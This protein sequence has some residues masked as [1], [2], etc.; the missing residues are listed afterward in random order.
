MC[1]NDLP[2]EGSYRLLYRTFYSEWHLTFVH[3]LYGGSSSVSN[4][5]A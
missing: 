4:S 2:P 1:R 3:S 5:K